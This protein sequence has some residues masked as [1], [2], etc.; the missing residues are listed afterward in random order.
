[1][2]VSNIL[3]IQGSYNF[4][5]YW[6]KIKKKYNMTLKLLT[7]SLH[8]FFFFFMDSELWQNLQHYKSLHFKQ[9]WPPQCIRCGMVL[10]AT[11]FH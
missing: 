5:D 2:K 4:I 11:N 8:F 3:K 7:R 6:L 10:G 9:N 1:M